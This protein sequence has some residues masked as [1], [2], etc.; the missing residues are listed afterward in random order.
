MSAARG[1]HRRPAAVIVAAGLIVLV[2]MGLRQSFGIFMQPI[3]C[4]LGVDRETF[5]L[6]I[7]V[8]NLMLGL[9]LAGYLADR[10][11]PRRVVAVGA[12]L[13]VFAMFLMTDVGG[14][15]G[16]LLV[17]GLLTGLAQ[18]ATT[19]VVVLA[20][21]ARVVPEQRRGSAFGV[22]TGLG[23]FGLFLMV[24]L[25][26]HWLLNGG[27]H[28]AFEALAWTALLMLF[29]AYFLP[30]DRHD[31]AASG[32]LPLVRRAATH[33]GY[34]LLIAGF[35]VC[36]F[37]VAFI[38]THLPAYV[39]DS[40][41]DR[42]TAAYALALVGLFNIVGS[43][44]FGWLG[45]RHRKKH[46]L[47]TL[48]GIRALIIAG[49]LVVPLTATSALVFGALIGV[50]WLATVPVTSGLV[51]QLF[52]ARYLG[53]LYGV[54]FLGHQV[55]AFLGAWWAGRVFDATGSYSIVWWVAVVLSVGAALIHWLL[56]DRPQALAA[57]VA[58]R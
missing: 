53:T 58:A 54:V 3:G 9:P 12:L 46:V 10:F 30:D 6:A 57:P 16:L 4:V 48:Y 43:L 34:L 49:F 22:V 8:Q 35:F 31:G 21:V 45:D 32:L 26:N 14:A 20:A 41:L 11:A 56:D 2:S 50:V 51:G 15:P 25:A 55:G 37:H 47:A 1:W 44:L 5:G 33:R 23:S 18:S 7:A 24:P 19:Y 13:Y 29:A 28:W 17:L 27:W 42:E 40:G 36:G 52:G 38:A 39:V